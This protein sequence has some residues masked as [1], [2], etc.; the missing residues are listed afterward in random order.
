MNLQVNLN[1]ILRKGS[2]DSELEFQRASVID[3]QLRLLIKDHPELTDARKQLRS[4]LKAY[5]D[6]YWVNTEIT[7]QQIV[8]SELASQIAE[9]ENS[10][11]LSRKKIIRTKLKEIGITQK[12]LG[13][14]LGHTSETY[15]S[16]LIN[17]INPFTL[18][19]LIIIHKVLHIG[20][21]LLIPTTLNTQIIIRVISAVSKLN[22]PKLKL[23][24]E[25]LVEA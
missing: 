13:I 9:Q 6:K 2:L 25:D 11:N 3:R 15:I 22:N 24:V 18:N 1:K 8:E 23:E 7:D 5:E 14:I 19:D 17:G 4:I 12:E 20:M 21:E 10:F 16:E